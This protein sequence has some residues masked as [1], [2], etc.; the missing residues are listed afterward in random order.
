MYMA[1]KCLC[2]AFMTH[3]LNSYYIQKFL[4]PIPTGRASDSRN[5]NL[6]NLIFFKNL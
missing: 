6:Y 4:E 5:Q 2:V 3:K 1:H